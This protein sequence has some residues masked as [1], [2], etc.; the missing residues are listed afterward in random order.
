M[1]TREEIAAE[2]KNVPDDKLNEL[3]MIIKYLASV[4]GEGEGGTS[5]MAR[6]RQIQISAAPDFS[7]KATL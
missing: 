4:K 2:I 5:T 1:M 7:T 3:Y 6:L